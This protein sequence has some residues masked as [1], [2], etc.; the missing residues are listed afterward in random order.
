MKVEDTQIEVIKGD[1]TEI[2]ADAI[3]NAANNQ[4]KMGGGVA[5]AILKKGGPEI[6]KEADKIT[7]IKVGESAVT[8]AGSLKARYVIHAATM[9]MDFKTNQEII[10]QAT[11]SS[12]DITKEKEIKSLAFCALGCGVGRFPLDKA[13]RI[14]LEEVI[15]YAKWNHNLKKVI[16]VLYEDKAYKIFL[17]ILN[18]RF[19][20]TMEKLTE[21]PIPT[22]DII[23]EKEGEIVLIKRKNPPF[24]WA[25]P[26]GFCELN[27]TVETG[28]FREAEEE[29]GLQVKD[30]KQFHVY[31]D[32]ERDPRFHTI[33]V[34][35]TAK[36]DGEP[37]AASDA[38]EA[39]YFSESN[40]PAE[41]AFD[42]KKIIED[43]F[44]SRK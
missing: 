20:R 6:Q 13:A 33:S 7:P 24:G 11:R 34:V 30:L 21:N 32:P 17:D 5:G 44:K 39:K 25:L 35:F 19:S 43:Y 38:K 14:M 2:K 9:A 26:G 12:L 3:V 41:I 42:H 15:K 10:R 16:F 36:A 27:E 28:A 31:S 29:T 40:L 18:E 23:I 37:K 1:I 4:L 8:G 22:V